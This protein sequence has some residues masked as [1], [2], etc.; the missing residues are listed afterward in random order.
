MKH[1]IK[2]DH[3][4]ASKERKSNHDVSAKVDVLMNRSVCLLMVFCTLNYVIT[5]SSKM[6]SEFFGHSKL[7]KS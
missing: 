7:F 4:K 1:I 6:F 3:F 2:V 5:S